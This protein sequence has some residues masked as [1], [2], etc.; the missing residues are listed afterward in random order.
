MI[1]EAGTGKSRRCFDEIGGELRASPDGPPLVLLVPEQ[2]TQA[3]D[4]V[5]AAEVG[6]TV[7][8]QSFSFRRLA[9][10]VMQEVGGAA[11]IH[12]D[13]TGIKMLLYK[14]A[15][16]RQ[17][18]L[19]AFRRLAGGQGWIDAVQEWLAECKRYR[20]DSKTLRTFAEKEDGEGG[21]HILKDKL[22]DLSMLFADLENE[23]SGKYV[24]SEDYLSMLADMI[25]QSTYIK[26]ARIWVDGF[27]GFTPSEL[28]VL[29][30]LFR[31]AAEVTVTL[32]L[33]RDY[34]EWE[35]PDELH[36]FHPTASTLLQLKRAA[37]EEYAEVRETVL[38]AHEADEW[39]HK[40][41]PQLAAL[42]HG[43]V[44]RETGEAVK[45]RA[46]PVG[47]AV[48]AA[49][50]C[51]AAHPRAETE[52]AARE[53]VRLAAE[54]GYRWRDVAV[55]VRDWERYADVLSSVFADYGIPYFLDQ[56]RAVLHHP[57]CELIRSALEV[58][59]S[60][61][62]Y[63]SVFRCVK[64]DLLL[65]KDAYPYDSIARYA[66]D[67]LENYV[68][69]YGIRGGRWTE[70]ARWKIIAMASLEDEEEQERRGQ[71][72]LKEE[73]ELHRSR[74]LVAA[75]LR[76]LEERLGKAATMRDQAEA[77]YL[78]LEEC[79]VPAKLEAWREAAEN[80]GQPELA[81]E[82]D[83][84][85]DRVIDTLDQLAELVGDEP[86]DTE[87]FAGMLG[88]GLESIRMGLV[89]PALDGV[90]AGSLDRTRT[91][92][93]KRL[94]LLGVND[95]VI[96]M[97]PKENGAITET[98]REKLLDRGLRIAP[99]AR[100]RLLDER[101]L[102]YCAIALPSDGLWVSYSLAD[103]EGKTLLPSEYVRVIKQLAPGIA[104]RFAAG[105]PPAGLS[106]EET[107]ALLTGPE[108]AISELLPQ[109][110]RWK[111]G[112]AVS[113]VWWAVYNWLSEHDVW[114][115]R[116]RDLTPSLFYSNRDSNLSEATARGLYG[117]VLRSSVSRLER[118]AACPFSHFAAYGL[119]LKER[120]MY[121]LE[122][123]DIGQL[124]HASL[125]LLA[126][127]LAEE[128]RTW[129]DM[130]YSECIER[131]Y[132]TVEELAP[133]LM[134]EILFSSNRHRYITRKL[135]NVVGRTAS[136]LREQA[137]R[138]GFRQAAAE[139]EFGPD[140]A[141][142]PLTFQLPNG[143]V[144]ELSG[145]ID[146]ID[147]AQRESG[148]Y[149]RVIDYKSRQ[150]R[151]KL[152]DVYYGLSLQLLAYLDA[153]ARHANLLLGAPAEPAGALYF[154]VHRPTLARNNA[155]ERER[156]EYEQFRKFKMKGLLLN[157]EVAARLMDTGTD[158]GHS[159]V[160]P[161]EWKTDGTLSKRSSAAD[162]QSLELL[163]AFVREKMAELG[164]GV[165][166]GIVQAAPYRRGAETACTFC[167]LK[168]VCGFDADLEGSEYRSLQP[169]S[170]DEVWERLGKEDERP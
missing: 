131:A 2:M 128:G 92:G 156:A 105:E 51:A 154:H 34:D 112:E 19:R 16:R 62:S 86:A 17:K 46:L 103:P 67:K 69:E 31:H 42:I 88:A 14:I 66:M 148:W 82:H 22:S 161:L 158:K 53:I 147:G 56:K 155:A 58:V 135:K 63:D 43:F 32:C 115:D 104:E 12:I 110:R 61:W 77:L 113:G 93:V 152:E 90:L 84:L 94:F 70:N 11:R 23:L 126:K 3:A 101:Y 89:P 39:R 27:H 45:G 9:F 116:L 60:R 109:L 162:A 111:R 114:R 96:P 44:Q 138:S 35:E 65:P 59:Q 123:P 57:L 4:R 169:L 118:F 160:V 29:Q 159:P 91:F 75:P 133:R 74:T 145:R 127:R 28:N 8:A 99:D 124:Y 48:P 5:F 26:N 129:A 54:E 144:M 24:D 18:E 80:N 79:G 20:V 102:L 125:S 10:R 85:W 166:S 121:R 130:S 164:T 72:L 6:G 71:Q 153:A 52:A 107:A 50:L 83:Q 49:K 40:D 38:L 150:H 134:A 136:I 132:M 87:L 119:R 47:G 78:L 41:N 97:R 143:V 81:R 68:L 167:K 98:E 13:D 168:P 165:S 106:D 108:R 76:R 100:R 15:R 163:R 157:E 122:A 117:A 55:F 64:T 33:D 73:E 139:L 120:R 7:R 137:V 21:L 141:I 1:G 25:P 149:M 36:L 30:R 151:L 170:D 142:P 146:R 140:G 95:G 37:Q